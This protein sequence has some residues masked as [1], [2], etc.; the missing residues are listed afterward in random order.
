M[1]A[2]RLEEER[3]QILEVEW[4]RKEEALSKRLADAQESDPSKR[5]RK[6]SPE[7]GGGKG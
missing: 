7:A 3:K 5:D 6:K 2:V 1:V 4:A